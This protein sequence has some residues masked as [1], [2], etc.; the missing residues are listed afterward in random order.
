MLPL[1]SFSVEQLL[2]SQLNV[3]LGRLDGRLG[4][5]FNGHPSGHFPELEPSI[6]QILRSIIL[7]HEILVTENGYTLSVFASFE[8][9]SLHDPSS[10][11][12]LGHQAQRPG[13][14]NR[15]FVLHL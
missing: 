11:G 4:F 6:M 1:L 10:L 14:V 3:Q 9:G 5:K 2:H 13:R 15:F 12:S 7:N 8:N